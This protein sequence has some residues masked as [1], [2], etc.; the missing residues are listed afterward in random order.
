[1]NGKALTNAHVFLEN[2]SHGTKTDINGNWKIEN[3]PPGS[4]VLII[5][6]SGFNS[7]KEEINVSKDLSL[8]V[9]LEENINS[10]PQLVIES[11]TLSLG[12]QGMRDL[13]GSVDYIGPQELK[14][15]QHSNVNN[16]LKSIPGINIQEEEGFGLRPNI[17]LRGSGLERSSKIT[18]M[19]DGIL[20]APAPYAAPSAY[21]FPTV[22]RMNGVEVMKGSS[23]WPIHAS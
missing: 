2:S 19:E 12:K 11:N 13:P 18:L 17:G 14:V 6:S 3:V 1:M 8:N 22:G 21:Y 9:Q 20:A 15:Y 23:C 7:L 5:S 4:Y 10:L 16:I